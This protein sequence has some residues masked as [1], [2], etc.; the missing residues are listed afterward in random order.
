MSKEEFVELTIKIPKPIF[1]YLFDTEIKI[2]DY[3]TRIVVEA[4]YSD[5]E[6]N[7]LKQILD[8]YNLKPVFRGL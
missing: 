3:I 5:I 6:N 2:E 1:T 7:T 8:K 4:V